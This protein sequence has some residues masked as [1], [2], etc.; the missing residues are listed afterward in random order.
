MSSPFETRKRDTGSREESSLLTNHELSQCVRA[1]DVEMQEDFAPAVPTRHISNGEYMPLP[2]TDAQKR[3]EARTRELADNAARRQGLARRTFLGSAGGLAASFLAMNEVHGQFFRVDEREMF[4]HG[5]R[6]GDE[7]DTGPDFA[8]GAPKNLFVFD[9]QLH[10]VRGSNATGGRALRAIAQGPSTPGYTSNP[11]NPLNQPDENGNVWGVWNPELVGLP[12]TADTFHIIQWMKDIYFDS[13]VTVGLVSNV[14]ASL[15][16]PADAP[17]RPPK[18]VSESLA[19]ELLTAEQTVAVRDYVNRIAGSK[20]CLA[21]GLMY[22]GV[23]NADY[24]Q[25]Q[26]DNYHPDA[27]KGYCISNA[28][29]VDTNPE[30][31]MRQWRLDDENVA[32]PTY[33]VISDNDRTQR[34]QHPG[35]NNICVH[36]GLSTN[37]EPLPELGHPSDI[38][39]AARDWPH[40]NFIIY[41]SCIKP[42][43]FDYNALADVLS[44]RLR[45]GV[46]DIAWTTEFAVLARPYRNVYA[47]IGTTFASSVVTF[48]TVTAHILGQLLKFLGPD[49]IL[50]G[51][52]SPWYGSPQWQIDALWRFEIPK[53][54]QRQYG[55]PP[56]TK[57]AK[58]Q[59][60]GLNAA[61]LY[62][63]QAVAAPVSRFGT[64]K[65]VPG[66]YEA[67][68][69]PEF[70]ATLEFSATDR[71]AQMRT[72]YLA[73]EHERSNTR[74][75]W[76]KA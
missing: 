2:Q 44:G 27:W 75:G 63:V 70:K 22:T 53:W 56:L 76:V 23:G 28:A 69:T 46:P 43:F 32:Y 59:I 20:R 62:G 25:F 34:R 30:S 66:N 24:I 17:P 58:R 40:L 49:R 68:M 50:F 26:I 4:R 12:L 54:M 73:Q 39:K 18:N 19:G 29:K 71:L 6:A 51:S 64:Y 48:P 8:H 72:E 67:L 21:H 33:Q 36:K 3:V 10:V 13:Q 74:Y 35:F 16:S 41:H 37:A 60:L 9:D 52:D 42:A 55:Y 15:F 14:T 5:E 47:E 38:P 45:K 11:L 7:S 31:L 65:P 61:R 1:D 57:Q